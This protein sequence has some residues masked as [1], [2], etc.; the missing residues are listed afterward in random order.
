MGLLSSLVTSVRRLIEIGTKP[1]RGIL[2]ML[3]R[4][5]G[6][7]AG[8]LSQSLRLVAE[9]AERAELREP[10]ETFR[11]DLVVMLQDE[12]KV[13]F[14]S[15]ADPSKPLIH[16]FMTETRLAEKR[17]YYAPWK[18]EIQ[19]PGISRI[20]E[21]YISAYFDELKSSD[22]LMSEIRDEMTDEEWSAA[23]SIVSYQMV[24]LKHNK[25]QPY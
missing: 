3:R 21:K 6:A 12:A 22:D 20:Q 1:T 15:S 19:Y 23:Y 13:K 18:V 25:N 5:F 4:Q 17:L 16:R 24:N 14:V 11:S 9:A 8:K 10:M 2:R 7:A